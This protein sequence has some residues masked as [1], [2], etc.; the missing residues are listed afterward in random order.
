MAIFSHVVVG[1]NDIEKARGFYD[2]V[3]GTLGIGRLIDM[4][5][6]SM[7]GNG[8][9]EFMVIKPINGEA[10]C[11]ANGGTIGFGA[12]NSETVD[13]FHAAALAKGGVCEGAP[14]PRPMMPGLYAA[15]VRD[16]DGNK[17]CAI[18]FG[19]AE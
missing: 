18:H 2:D 5:D 16:P 6:R 11:H 8:A 12:A 15:Y 14:G 3:L 17:I 9:P 10:A 7:W 19:K 1:T 4:D 13:R